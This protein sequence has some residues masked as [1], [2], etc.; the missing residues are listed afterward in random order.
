MAKQQSKGML[1]CGSIL[2]ALGEL[3]GS[4]QS[5][6]K[7]LPIGAMLAEQGSLNLLY[8]RGPGVVQGKQK[9]I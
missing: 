7:K 9:A 1:G 8:E 2:E 3:L 4:L 5:S 6:I